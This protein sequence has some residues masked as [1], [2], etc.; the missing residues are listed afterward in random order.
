MTGSGSTVFIVE[1]ATP[2]H[3]SGSSLAA[4]SRGARIITTRTA[5]SV[6][7]VEVLD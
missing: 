5:T 4:L 3:K 6:V 1:D 2:M 7:P